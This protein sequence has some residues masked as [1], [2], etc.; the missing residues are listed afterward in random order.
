M[1]KNIL[2]IIVLK[3]AKLIKFFLFSNKKE[4]GFIFI[5]SAFNKNIYKREVKK[6]DVSEFYR[7][8][9]IIQYKKYEFFLLL[10]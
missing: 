2:Q 7:E 6:E 10:E 9:F 4:N 3:K 8:Y 1:I 5:R